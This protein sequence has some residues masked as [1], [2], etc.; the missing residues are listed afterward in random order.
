MASCFSTGRRDGPALQ[1]MQL[2]S[3]EPP[4]LSRFSLPRQIGSNWALTAAH[5]VYDDDDEE[6]LPA[7]FLSLM[8]GV[9]DRRRPVEDRRWEQE[10]YPLKDSQE[11][12][13]HQ[14]GGGPLRL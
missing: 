7:S 13:S 9:W 12:G 4:L 5:C 11:K 8:L 14:P 3:C 1:P 2:H 6:V 10:Q